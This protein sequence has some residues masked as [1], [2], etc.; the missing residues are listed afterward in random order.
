MR[1]VG[2]W[3]AKGGTASRGGNDRHRVEQLFGWVEYSEMLIKYCHYRRAADHK[4]VSYFGSLINPRATQ[5]N[6]GSF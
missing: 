5:A 2:G 1:R 3:Q 6:D 4:K